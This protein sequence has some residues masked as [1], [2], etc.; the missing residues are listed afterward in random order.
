MLCQNV[1]SLLLPIFIVR[2]DE[3]TGN[4]YIQLRCTHKSLM[5]QFTVYRIAQ[6]NITLVLLVQ[7]LSLS[8]VRRGIKV[9][10][11]G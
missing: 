9:R 8:L 1:T 5:R 11:A 3:R 2:I 6:R 4:I 7:N 10:T